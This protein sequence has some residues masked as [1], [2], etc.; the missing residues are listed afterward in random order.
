LK[1]QQAIKQPIII[2][3]THKKVCYTAA[4][5]ELTFKKRLCCCKAPRSVTFENKVESVRMA[6]F[7]KQNTFFDDMIL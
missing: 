2:P 6:A 1:K 5:P 3:E 7:N 4:L